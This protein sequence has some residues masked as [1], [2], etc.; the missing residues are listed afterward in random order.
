MGWIADVVS[1]QA[2]SS[3]IQQAINILDH[4]IDLRPD[5]PSRYRE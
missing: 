1:A 2:L 5:L 3:K 4:G